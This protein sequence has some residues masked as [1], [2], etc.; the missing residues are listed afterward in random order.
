M[1]EIGYESRR[2]LRVVIYARYS[3][4]NQREESID[5][6]IRYCK[7]FIEQNPEYELVDIYFDEAKT[8]KEDIEN[9]VDF[10]RMIMDSKDDKYDVILVH[11]FSRFAR[12]KLDSSI[13]KHKLREK[14]I[15]V[16]SVSQHI[17]DSPEGRMMESFLEA[18]DEYYSDNLGLEVTK[19]LRENAFAGKHT[20]GIAPLGFRYDD[21]LKLRE[22]KA[23]SHIVR[24]VFDLYIQGY[25]SLS[26]ASQLN[27]KGYTGSR[28]KPF[29]HTTVLHMLKNERYAGTF[30]YDIGDEHFRIENNHDAIIDIVTFQKVQEI[31]KKRGNKPKVKHDHIYA[32]TGKAT[33]G[34][35]GN[36]YHG[37]GYSHKRI[38]NGKEVFVYHYR[39]VNKER[40]TCDNSNIQKSRLESH[41]CEYI[42]SNL[43]DD[44]FIERVATN[45]EAV[46]NEYKENQPKEAL[47][48]LKSEK[49]KLEEQ[50]G[51]LLDLYL[52]PDSSIDKDTL[53]DRM[54]KLKKRIRGIDDEIKSFYINEAFALTKE[55]AVKYLN[56]FKESFDGKDEVMVKSLIDTF[57]EKVI[58]HKDTIDITYKVDFNRKIH[59]TIGKADNAGDEDGQT[60]PCSIGISALADIHI[61]PEFFN[62]NIE[63]SQL[64][65]MR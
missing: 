53:N 56:G 22:D 30:L 37:A 44:S 61:P 16:I 42:L 60:S 6:Q 18:I 21:N 14:G 59:E 1:K 27:Q 55:D 51:K 39:C 40:R 41:I 10:Q 46:L 52:D 31:L 8:A 2:K 50:K 5:A 33:C 64:Q 54:D 7:T 48:G 4:E 36:S 62:V 65:G 28:G 26:I 19:G 13:Y 12:N 58:I 63:R 15:K 47:E 34:L 57:V 43:L 49:R 25:G 32:L 17:D 38:E 20:G 24:Y 3:S 9:R 45:F 29:S 23:T 35:C 11:K